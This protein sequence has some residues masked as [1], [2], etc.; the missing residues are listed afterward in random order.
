[1]LTANITQTYPWSEHMLNAICSSFKSQPSDEEDQQHGVWKESG[2]V[3]NL[4]ERIKL[5]TQMMLLLFKTD[6]N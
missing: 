6:N 1:M 5:T 4:R 2:E 3:R